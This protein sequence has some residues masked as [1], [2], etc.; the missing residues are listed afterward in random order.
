MKHEPQ[1]SNGVLMCPQCGSNNLC[2]DEVQVFV[3]RGEDKPGR[4][5]TVH[6]ADVTTVDTVAGFAGRRSDLRIRF[7]CE[8]CPTVSWL[9]IIQHKGETITRWHENDSGEVWAK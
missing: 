1:L 6:G 9:Y 2:H 4:R 7:T 3:R 5:T 8:G